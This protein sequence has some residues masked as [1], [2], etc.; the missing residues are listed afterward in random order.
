[1]IDQQANVFDTR[2]FIRPFTHALLLTSVFLVFINAT[3][4]ELWSAPG[5]M[6]V[7]V[8]NARVLNPTL[9]LVEC[10]VSVSGSEARK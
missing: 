8:C 4:C 5:I 2:R 7:S 9:L 1:M 6:D 3:N 10:C